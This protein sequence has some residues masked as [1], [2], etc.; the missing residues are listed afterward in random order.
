MFCDKIM[1]P[2]FSHIYKQNDNSAPF[3]NITAM[4]KTPKE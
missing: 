4:S 3:R 1:N 2:S